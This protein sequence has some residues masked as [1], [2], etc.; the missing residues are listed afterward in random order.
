MKV[1]LALDCSSN[2]YSSSYNE[3]ALKIISGLVADLSLNGID[4]DL[5]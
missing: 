3:R 5:V 2:L 4:L 1:Y